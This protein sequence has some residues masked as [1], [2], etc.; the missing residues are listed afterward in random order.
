MCLIPKNKRR[1]IQVED[2]GITPYNVGAKRPVPPYLKGLVTKYKKFSHEFKL[3]KT[4][5]LWVI[6]RYIQRK[7]QSIPSWTGFNILLRTEGLI[8]KDNIG[9]LPTINHPATSMS[10]IHE[11]LCQALKI[12]DQLKLESIVLVCDQAIY[13]FC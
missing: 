7:S 4:D 2:K 12:K 6:S 9:Y 1:S 5:M 13:A 3:D 11:M 10:T 8:M